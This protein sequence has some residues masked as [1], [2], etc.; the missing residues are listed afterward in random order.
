M[1]ITKFTVQACCGRQ[2][3]IF[4]TDQPITSKVLEDLLK[5]G[6]NEHTHF[7]KAGILYMDNSDFIVTGPIGSDRLQVKCKAADCSQKLNNLE[8]LLKKIG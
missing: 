3:I 6:F 1:N 5:S 7:T 2:S 8:E 4:K